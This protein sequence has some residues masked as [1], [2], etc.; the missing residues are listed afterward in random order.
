MARLN[1][2]QR[3]NTA[4]MTLIEILLSV[5]IMG[6]VIGAAATVYVSSVRMM[7]QLAAIERRNDVVLAA[8]FISMRIGTANLAKLDAANPMSSSQLK[9]RIDCD[10]N[11]KMLNTPSDFSDDL[12]VKFRVIGNRLRWRTDAVEAGDVGAG[13]PELI[14]GLIM[15]SGTFA[16]GELSTYP[17]DFFGPGD[18]PIMIQM[19][20]EATISNLVSNPALQ[21]MVSVGAKNNNV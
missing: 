17:V 3:R 14:P 2:S 1:L 4:G 13:D 19:A 20:F 10:Q 21:T 11:F 5:A 8:Q 7:N 16:N 18:E 6:I 9:L 15:A 12:W